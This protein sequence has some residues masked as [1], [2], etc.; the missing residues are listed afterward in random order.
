MLGRRGAGG[1]GVVTRRAALIGAVLLV[2]A[3]A[4]LTW[5]LVSAPPGAGLR[6][7][8]AAA[9][10]AGLGLIERRA[11][12]PPDP[13]RL[14]EAALRGAVSAVG[15]PHSAY[16]D[17]AS[18]AALRAGAA[19]RHSGVGL[20]LIAGRGGDPVV[21]RVVAGSPAAMSAY[22]GAAP[23]AA[24]GL[25]PGDRLLSVDG[26]PTAGSGAAAVR[27]WLA[28]AP[29]TEVRV[30]VAR[31]LAA[32]GS[33]RLEFVLV[34]RVFTVSAV[35]WSLLPG[36]IGDIAIAGFNAETAPQLAAAVAALRARGARAV[37]ID[38]R[39]DPGGLV[40]AAQQVARYL[41]PGGVLGYLQPGRGARQPVPVPRPLRPLGLPYA[42]LVNGY[43]A[44]AAELLAAAV[45]DAGAAPVVGQRTFGKA[46]VQRVFP[47]PGGAALK[48]TVARYLTPAGRDLGGRGVTPDVLI[49]FPDP[50]PGRIG[51]PATDPQLAAAMVLLQRRLAAQGRTGA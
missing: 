20:V 8:P 47:L 5:R 16:L 45:Q 19:G 24:P 6:S 25:R 34:R 23:G 42:V 33:R 26:R 9:V 49:P 46:T 28:G 14:A 21:D 3:T 38:L 39:D 32:G 29:G 22:T 12:H 10:A 43:S 31:P 4:A 17:P 11:L 50:P 1:W 40:S 44:S 48:L 2:C 27:G 36:R 15:D 18:Y 41:L 7:P 37:V 30:A 35:S 51:R 13:G